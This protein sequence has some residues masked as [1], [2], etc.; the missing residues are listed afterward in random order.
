MQFTNLKLFSIN[1]FSLIFLQ[2]GSK[3]V[4]GIDGNQL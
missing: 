3:L 4:N 1:A 2:Y